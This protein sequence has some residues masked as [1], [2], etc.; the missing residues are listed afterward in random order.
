MK[1]A[2]L[3]YGVEGESVYNYY[4]AKFPDASFAVYDNMPEPKNPAILH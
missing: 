2:I 3:G 4:R 1:I